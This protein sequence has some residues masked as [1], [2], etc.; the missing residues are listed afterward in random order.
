LIDLAGVA[1]YEDIKT[2]RMVFKKLTGMS[3]RDY[4]KKYARKTALL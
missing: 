3:P 2:F 4:R 1:G